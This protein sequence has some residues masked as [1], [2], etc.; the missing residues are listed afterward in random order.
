MLIYN[1]PNNRSVIGIPHFYDRLPLSLRSS[2]LFL[3]VIWFWYAIK[4]NL[5][6]MVLRV[7]SIRILIGLNLVFAGL[8]TFINLNDLHWL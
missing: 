3:L 4:V 5:V 7:R 6:I 8:T 2:I 1:W